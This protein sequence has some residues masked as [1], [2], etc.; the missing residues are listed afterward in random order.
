L[1]AEIADV[2]ATWVVATLAARGAIVHTSAAEP[3]RRYRLQTSL[4]TLAPEE[5]A[6]AQERH[7]ARC[8]PA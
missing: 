4:V 3:D 5:I 6:Q 7:D 8:L 1:A 2:P